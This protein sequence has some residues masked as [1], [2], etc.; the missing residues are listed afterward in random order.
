MEKDM[1]KKQISN[2]I[3]VSKL[4]LILSQ[5]VGE[6]T[7][8]DMGELYE[9]VFAEEYTNKI[10][11]TRRLRKIIDALQMQGARICSTRSSGGCNGYFVSRTT[12]ELDGYCSGL[13]REALRKLKKESVMRH[14]SLL[15]LL[16]QMQF[17][18]E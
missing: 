5:H 11:H 14:I 2:E 13:R 4:W 12:S 7:A 1:E 10:N 18:M 3:A 9:L 8:I 6:E 17:N 16:G 15:E